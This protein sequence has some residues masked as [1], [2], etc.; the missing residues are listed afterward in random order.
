VLRIGDGSC[1]SGSRAA[2]R[3]L[4]QLIANAHEEDRAY[5]AEHPRTLTARHNV[6]H[7]TGMAGDAATARDLFAGLLPVRDRVSGPEHPDTLDALSNLAR[8]TRE[9]GDAAG[10]RDQYAALLAVRERVQGPGPGG[11]GRVWDQPVEGGIDEPNG[12]GVVLA[13]RVSGQL[14][15]AHPH[16]LI[17]GASK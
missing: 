6:A 12:L 14:P 17:A 9:A 16:A 8:W 7:W 10:A 3:D 13:R 5:G 2:A 4:F 1:R 15:P 11:L